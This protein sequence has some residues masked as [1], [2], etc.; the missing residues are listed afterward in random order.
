MV[1]DMIKFP[2]TSLQQ[3]NLDWIMQQL[4]KILQFMPLNGGVVIFIE[5]I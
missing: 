2:F 4:H 5:N 3:L 1:N